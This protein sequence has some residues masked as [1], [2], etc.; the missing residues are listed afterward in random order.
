MWIILLDHS[1]SMFEPFSGGSS[2]VQG[3]LRHTDAATRWEAA[4]DAVQ[5]E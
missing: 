5:R 1:P 3:R 4:K 2:E